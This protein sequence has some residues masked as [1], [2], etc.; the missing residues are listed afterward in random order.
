MKCLIIV[1][2]IVFIIL[3]VVFNELFEG[4]EPKEDG[5]VID[6]NR[7]TTENVKVESVR[8]PITGMYTFMKTLPE[9]VFM[10]KYQYKVT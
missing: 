9:L 3:I 4:Y 6:K 5:W 1:S 8:N 2:I 7:T 10:I